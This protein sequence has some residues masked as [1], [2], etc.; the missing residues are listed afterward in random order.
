ME[1][2]DFARYRNTGTVGKVVEIED[3]PDGQWILLDTYS[4]FY[5]SSTL[6]PAAEAD[7]KVKVLEETSLD[8]QMEQAERMKAQIEEA[9]SVINRITPSGT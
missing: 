1:I 9:E 5:E 6:E 7:Y 3:R 2:G 8:R 4:L